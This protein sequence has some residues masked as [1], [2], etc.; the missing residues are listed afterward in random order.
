VCGCVWVSHTRIDGARARRRRRQEE[1]TRRAGRAG[2]PEQHRATPLALPPGEA[3]GFGPRAR[4]PGPRRARAQPTGTAATRHAERAIDAH[5]RQAWGAARARATFSPLVLSTDRWRAQPFVR[6][7]AGRGARLQR[8]VRPARLAQPRTQGHIR[9]SLGPETTALKDG[10]RTR[11]VKERR[12][13][14][15]SRGV[16]ALGVRPWPSNP[17]ALRPRSI[18]VARAARTFLPAATADGAARASKG[19]RSEQ[20]GKRSSSVCVSLGS[21]ARTDASSRRDG[22]HGRAFGRS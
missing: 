7:P 18:A 14:G 8:A 9:A 17:V 12:G 11:S 6:G 3:Q 1:R 19:K 5:R 22:V 10:R 4:G 20:T 13:G 16:C 15:K 21:E 2:S